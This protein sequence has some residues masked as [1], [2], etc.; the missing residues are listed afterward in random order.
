VK[1]KNKIK[2]TVNDLD[3]YLCKTLWDYSKKTECNDILNIWKITFQALDGKGNQ[4]LDLLDDNYCFI[5]P[6]YVKGGP[7]L[8]SFRHS[9]SLYVCALRAITNHAPIREYRLRFFL[10]EE[11]KYPC[12]VYPIGFRRYILHDYTRFNNY[13]NLKRDSLSHFVMFLKA[14]PNTFAFLDNSFTT[15]ISKPYS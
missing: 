1:R 6:S 5:K 9:N 3:I 2:S 4:F 12:D 8:Q 13:W 15:S 14:N 11:F 10:R 7:W